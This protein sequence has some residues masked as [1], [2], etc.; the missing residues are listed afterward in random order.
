MSS[1]IWIRV[2]PTGKKLQLKVVVVKPMFLKVL[3]GNVKN[4]SDDFH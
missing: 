1:N 2:Y 3:T 4:D